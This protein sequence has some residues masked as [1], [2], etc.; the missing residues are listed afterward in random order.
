LQEDVAAPVPEQDFTARLLTLFNGWIASL[1]A[2]IK[3]LIS[4]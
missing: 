3:G 2:T 4:K 1:R